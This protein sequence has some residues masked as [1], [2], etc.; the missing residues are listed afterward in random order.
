[1]TSVITGDVVNSRLRKNQGIWMNPLKKE[2]EKLGASP[3]VW[4]IY[5]GDSFQLEVA[6]PENALWEVI[7]IKAII[8]GVRGLDVRMAIG[9]GDKT[10]KSASVTQ[11][12]GTAFVYA[13][14]TFNSLE[15]QKRTLGVKTPWESFNKAM[16]AMLDLAL[17]QMDNWTN[18]A[19]QIVSASL[20]NPQMTQK[21]LAALLRKKS[22]SDISEGRKR[23]AYN[24]IM[25]MEEYYSWQ[26]KQY[27]QKK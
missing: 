10:Y 17:L 16:N 6:K 2:F 24:E 5:R 12:N 20:Q 22:Q 7:K 13:G 14:E 9:I 4:E 19:A 26:V 1:M 18:V 8:K 15:K 23:A 21:E 11:A 25:A 3:K 27:T